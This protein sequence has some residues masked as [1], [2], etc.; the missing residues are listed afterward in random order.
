MNDV[1]PT[2]LVTVMG[3]VLVAACSVGLS[4]R[5]RKWV[6]VSFF[7]HI[8]FA[9]AQVP[10]VLSFFGGGDMF[11]Y[12]NYGEILARMMERDP[13]HVIPEVTAL[14]LHNRPHLPLLILGTGTSTGTMSALAAWTFYLLGPSRYAACI[15][16]A[17]LSLCGKGLDISCLSGER[18][19][20]AS[21]A[22]GDRGTLRAVIRVLVFR[23]RQRG[24]RRGWVRL[25][26]V[27]SSFLDSGGTSGSW[28][29]AHHYRRHPNV[30]DQA[31][32]LVSARPCRGELVL[33]GS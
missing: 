5:E 9:C 20:G 22:R 33:L 18:R 15:A 27:R 11:L 19:F 31:I 14:L 30:A 21:L 7:M 12:F 3:A 32:H 16:L 6:T 1:F 4:R 13:L 17:M 26:F 8:G 23:L 25:V 24:G 29:G 2:L 10:L 28:M